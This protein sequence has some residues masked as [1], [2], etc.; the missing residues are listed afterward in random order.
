MAIALAVI[1]TTM[2]SSCAIIS[3]KATSVAPR[4]S[5]PVEA[6]RNIIL[7]IGY[8]MGVSHVTSAKIELGTLHMERLTAGGIATTFASNRLVTD[9][10]ASGTA[11]ATRSPYLAPTE[12]WS[13]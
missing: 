10:A 8:G 3:V 4:E 9:S 2:L 12:N 1:G 5:R 7:M 13:A 11:I 6:P